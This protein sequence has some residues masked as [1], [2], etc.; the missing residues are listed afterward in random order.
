MD[1]GRKI[2]VYY[3]WNGTLSVPHVYRILPVH[4]QTKQSKHLQHLRRSTW[5]EHRYHKLSFKILKNIIKTMQV[6]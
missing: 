6:M 1:S 5:T 4:R 2:K 3:L